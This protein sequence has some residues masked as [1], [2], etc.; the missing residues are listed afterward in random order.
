MPQVVVHIGD[1]QRVVDKSQHRCRMTYDP[2]KQD[3]VVQS[4]R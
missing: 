1:A 2:A 3:L 4:L